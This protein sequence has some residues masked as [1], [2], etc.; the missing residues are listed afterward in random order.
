[1]KMLHATLLLG[2][3][4]SRPLGLVAQARPLKDQALLAQFTRSN[5][6]PKVLP[7]A[8]LT[9]DSMLGQ[10]PLCPVVAA[11]AAQLAVSP[12]SVQRWIVGH[13]VCT[14]VLALEAEDLTAH[15]Y[16]AIWSVKFV[17]RDNQ[18]AE[19]VINRETGTVRYQRLPNQLT[20]PP[21]SRCGSGV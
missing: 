2:I 20:A 12:D 21:K 13:A 1:M 10:S 6:C 15:T 14:M 3:F 19:A 17:A 18:V 16:T 11:A 5:P 7:S 9:P 8:W 4:L